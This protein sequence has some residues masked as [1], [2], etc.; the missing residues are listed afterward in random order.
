MGEK[1]RPQAVLL[2][3]LRCFATS[4][5]WWRRFVWLLL[6]L[7]FAQFLLYRV[8]IGIEFA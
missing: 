1:N 3:V 2:C 4:R 5:W 8:Q 6:G 7:Q